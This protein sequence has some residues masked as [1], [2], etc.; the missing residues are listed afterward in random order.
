[1]DTETWKGTYLLGCRVDVFDN[2][3]L[4]DD[5]LTHLQQQTSQPG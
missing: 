3:E 2:W 1:M 5:P 4:L